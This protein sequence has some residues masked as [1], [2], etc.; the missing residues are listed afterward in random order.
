MAKLAG[1][2]APPDLPNTSKARRSLPAEIQIVIKERDEYKRDKHLQKRLQ[3]LKEEERVERGCRHQ[4]D[5]L[6]KHPIC[7]RFEHLFSQHIDGN[8]FKLNEK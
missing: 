6:S 3:H 8:T 2:L 5:S 7:K 1:G 4:G